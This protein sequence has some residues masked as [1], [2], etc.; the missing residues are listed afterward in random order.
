MSKQKEPFEIDRS[1]LFRKDLLMPHH[2]VRQIESLLKKALGL[3][4]IV[5]IL[6]HRQVGKTTLLEKLGSDYASLDDEEV[7]SK[8]QTQG[9]K[10]FLASMKGRPF[11]LDEAQLEPRLF[12]SLKEWVRTHKAPGQFLLSGSVRFTSRKAIQES[13]T[14]RI[15]SLELFPLTV[16]ELAG[17]P[18]PNVIATLLSTSPETLPSGMSLPKE[19]SAG[20][21]KRIHQYI[22]HGGLPGICFI[23]EPALRT[24]KIDEQLR[25]ILD[26]D[27]RLILKTNLPLSEL[28]A[29]LRA[30][31]KSQGQ[32]VEWSELASQ[33]RISVPTI[34]KLIEAF[35][36]LFLVRRVPIKGGK[37]GFSL[38]FE[39]IAEAAFL[40]GSSYSL[41]EDLAHFLFCH[42]RAEFEYRAG[43]RSLTFIYKTRGGAF[44]PLAY[45]TPRGIL[46]IIPCTQPTQN[47]KELKSALKNYLPSAYSF[48]RSFPGSR[49]ILAHR[50][51]T[52]VVL[53]PGVFGL[54]LTSLT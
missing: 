40:R 10:N 1:T 28:F 24:L 38:F 14:G 23:R 5:G 4:P 3:S 46:G 48:L 26:R 51:S 19:I 11:S 53:A 50:S 20:R 47:E 2:R 12:P 17:R 6:G 35:E 41:E 52:T 7:L 29:L 43:G 18:L 16:S 30:L 9:P 22:E 31:A 8:L 33:C 36:A 44:V 45:E 21:L 32:K 39:D 27:L 49:V 54:P 15:L 42:F 37:S 13:L 34:K 25:T